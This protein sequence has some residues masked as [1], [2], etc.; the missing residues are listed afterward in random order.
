MTK[1]KVYREY[2]GDRDVGFGTPRLRGTTA[3]GGY[4]RVGRLD[5]EGDGLSGQGL[6]ED[7][8]GEK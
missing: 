7:L 2:A 6:Y 1:G 3:S 4:V 8:F 5:V